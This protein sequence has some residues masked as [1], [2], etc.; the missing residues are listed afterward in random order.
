M[1]R[2]TPLKAI[3]LKCLDCA[4]TSD[5]VRQCQFTDCPLYTLHFGKAVPKGTSRL[6]AIRNK[7]LWCMN[8]TKKEVTHCTVTSCSL[9]LFR[10]G[11]NPNRSLRVIK[12]VKT[13]LKQP[14][15]FNGGIADRHF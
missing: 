13:A 3:R 10:E 2:I 5:E 8:G 7:C 11:R 9:Y 15:K 12:Q 6:K 1:K 4:G 14:L